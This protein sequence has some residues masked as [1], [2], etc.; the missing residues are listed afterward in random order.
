MVGY[1]AAKIITQS[2]PSASALLLLF[3][4]VGLGAVG[5]LDDF[6]KI[7]RAAQPGP[8]QPAKMIGQTVVALVFGC[9][10]LWPTLED[11]RGMTPASTHVSFLRDI[12][13]AGPADRAWRS[14]S[15]G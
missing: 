5:F 2:E 12:Q 7:S 9:L 6:I 4:F 14:C 10:A 1:F 3:L 13:L 15:S 11:D 8:A